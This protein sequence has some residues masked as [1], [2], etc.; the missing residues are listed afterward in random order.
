MFMLLTKEVEI[1]LN[2]RNIKYYEDKGYIIPRSKSELGTKIVVKL[3]TKILVKI[4]D[5]SIGS[6]AEIE[7][8]CDYCLEKGIKTII[9]QPYKRYFK[10]VINHIITKDAC[11]SCGCLKA[12]ETNLIK[13][14]VSSVLSLPEI[15][16]KSKETLFKNYGTYNRLEISNIKTKIIEAFNES[17]IYASC[18]QIY[19]YNL[20]GGRIN[21]HI[22]GSFLDIVFED[23]KIY[24]EYDGSGHDLK[25]KLGNISQEEFNNKERDRYYYFKKQGWTMIRIISLKDKLPQDDKIIEMIDYA[26][27]YLKS[28]HSWIRFDIDNYKV[29]NSQGEFEYGFGELR[30]IKKEDIKEIT[31]E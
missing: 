17:F 18:Q 10:N 20:L 24:I 11:K 8:L 7:C 19:L 31:N 16:K 9:K 29:I 21:L 5:V 13:Y 27:K 3:R 26:K 4:A 23:E 12:Q 30:Q 15:R 1:R 6:H 2:N 28:G 22:E 14:G 25:V